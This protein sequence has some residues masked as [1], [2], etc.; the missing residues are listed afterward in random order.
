VNI[1]AGFAGA[2]DYDYITDKERLTSAGCP[3]LLPAAA[4]Q[5]RLRML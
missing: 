3:C 5:N 2:I 4:G 1:G